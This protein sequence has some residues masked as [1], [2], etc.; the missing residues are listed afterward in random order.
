MTEAELVELDRILTQFQGGR[1]YK[2]E[3]MDQ[4]AAL[5]KQTDVPSLAGYTLTHDYGA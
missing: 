4:I 3:A 5:R 1:I 2:H